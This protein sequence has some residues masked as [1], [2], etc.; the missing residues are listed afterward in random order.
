MHV[1][2]LRHPAACYMIGSMKSNHEPQHFITWSKAQS[3]MQEKTQRA[4]KVDMLRVWAC[5][6]SWFTG[7]KSTSA[8]PG[9]VLTLILTVQCYGKV[10]LSGGSPSSLSKVGSGKKPGIPRGRLGPFHQLLGEAQSFI[11]GWC[12]LD[13]E[14]PENCA[15]WMAEP[16]SQYKFRTYLNMPI[17]VDKTILC[18]SIGMHCACSDRIPSE[19]HQKPQSLAII[20]WTLSQLLSVRFPFHC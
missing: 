3:K 8:S 2:D 12:W 11:A 18:Q 17:V 7:F 13:L 20:F 15:F 5:I 19:Q 9:I 16:P 1:D 10:N 4:I 6:H 14:S